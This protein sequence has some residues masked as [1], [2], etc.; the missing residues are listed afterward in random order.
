MK[1]VARNFFLS[2]VYFLLMIGV[3]SFF[4]DYKLNIALILKLGILFFCLFIGHLIINL[5]SNLS[6]KIEN[7]EFNEFK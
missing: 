2:L 1:L 5:L 7:Q 6:D 3:E 4:H